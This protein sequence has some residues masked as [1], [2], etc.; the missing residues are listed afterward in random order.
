M[1]NE[2]FNITGFDHVNACSWT[3]NNHSR[4]VSG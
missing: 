4:F 3:W 2:P 1:L